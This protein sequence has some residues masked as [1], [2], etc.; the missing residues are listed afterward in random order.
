MAN[1]DVTYSDIDVPNINIT[2]D[3]NSSI[4]VEGGVTVEYNPSTYSIVGDAYYATLTDEVP[5]WLSN[6]LSTAVND[7]IN[8]SLADLYNVNQNLLNA[9]YSLDVAKNT[10]TQAIIDAQTSYDSLVGQYESW[11][12]TF[13]SNSATIQKLDLA[14][15]N[16]DLAIASHIDSYRAEF[17]SEINAAVNNSTLALST[18]LGALAESQQSLFTAWEDQDGL[19][20]GY[21]NVSQKIS[22]YVGYDPAHPES[23]IAKSL[24]EYNSKLRLGSYY[25]ES[26]FGLNSSITHSGNGTISNPYS[27]EFW[28]KADRFKLTSA[29]NV[30]YTPFEIDSA[31]GEIRFKGK[32]S[33]SNVTGTS[34]LATTSAVNT[35]IANSGFLLPSGVQNAIRDNVTTIDGSKITTGSLDASAITADTINGHNI[36][37]G[38]ITGTYIT[39]TTIYGSSILGADIS[40]SVIKG[41]FIDLSST[42]YLTNWKY[43]GD[44]G[45]TKGYPV[46]PSAYASNFAKNDDGSFA[47]DSEGYVRLP[48]TAK[49][50]SA[51]A[52]SY[53]TVTYIIDRGDNWD[54]TQNLPTISTNFNAWDS[55]TT[56]STLR[57]INEYTDFTFGGEIINISLNTVSSSSYN[58]IHTTATFYVGDIKYVLYC[59]VDHDWN[60]VVTLTE[61]GVSKI[62]KSGSLNNWNG[63]WSAGTKSPVKVDY[64]WTDDR[65]SDW[66]NNMGISVVV[67]LTG[68][69]RIKHYSSRGYLV[70]IDSMDVSR[71]NDDDA[72]GVVKRRICSITPGELIV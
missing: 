52:T 20:A 38:T 26:G 61:D 22:G 28:I 39:G 32:V 23:T 62:N 19:I 59:K 15:A 55:Y 6:V 4:T 45:N 72:G 56:T 60:T 27:S 3:T 18:R 48:S 67:T 31:A 66:R 64:T 16:I 2:T 63:S 69:Y 8:G 35:A 46:V 24:F 14:Y 51:A 65:A 36:S 12:A 47:L 68:T 7:A 33:F 53:G 11:N 10:Y 9:L 49:V 1:V 54:S 29:S 37:G 30:S 40:G 34:G 25:Y 71:V 43:Y 17:S 42:L 50:G 5:P 70:K 57:L 41:S 13:A 21:A 58:Y 44:P